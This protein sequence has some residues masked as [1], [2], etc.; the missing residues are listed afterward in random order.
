LQADPFSVREFVNISVTPVN[1]PENTTFFEGDAARV[2]VTA[3]APESV[4][5]ELKI[6]DFLATMDLS[7]VQAG[8]PTSVPISVTCSSEV[9]RIQSYDP[10]QQTVHLEALGTITFPF[11]IRTQG[12]VAT[13]Y[14]AV[15]PVVIPSEV[16]IDGPLPYLTEVI[17]VTGTIDVTGASEDITAKVT[18]VPRDAEGRLVPGLQWT[19]DQVEV[20][21]GVRR[22]VNYKPDVQVV[23]DLR[24]EPATGYRRGGV[25]V[26]P[27][28]VTLAGPTS[29]LNEMPGFVKTLP[30][31][32]TGAIQDLT[33]RTPLT[34]PT[35]VVAVGVN[36]VT[37]TV[38]ILPILSSRTI[39]STVEVQGLSQGW[40]AILSPS[41]VE[42]SMV[43]PESLLNEL[44]EEDVQVF[45]N[46]FDYSLGV[47]RLEPVV[48]VPEDVTVESL[49]PETIEV[50]IQV[51]PTPPPTSTLTFEGP[52][53]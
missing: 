50:I 45:V 37:V 24:G 35:S 31:S 36:Y 29:V 26:N 34:M 6:S 44:V 11:E 41:V 32:V 23:P 28:S 2:T 21:I 14:Q 52:V 33:A 42:V 3:R 53:P 30:I 20:R 40:E 22:R 10:E 17:S 8:A 25:S 9:V 39:T 4:L 47:Y 12:E 13:G 49:I 27:S 43:G 5:A 38:E 46:L 18:V 1:Q 15:R 7:V 19:P 48:L 51:P 16:T